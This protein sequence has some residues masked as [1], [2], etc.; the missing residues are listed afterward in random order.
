MCGERTGACL[1][2]GVSL[3][4]LVMATLCGPLGSI[5]YLVR[6]YLSLVW[7][8]YDG[9]WGNETGLSAIS[10]CLTITIISNPGHFANGHFA[11]MSKMNISPTF[12]VFPH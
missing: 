3:L 6:L 8:G 4:A 9:G 7:P 12:I 2:G 10:G 1:K 5:S 11:K